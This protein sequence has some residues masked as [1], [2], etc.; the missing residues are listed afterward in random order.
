[1]IQ[2]IMTASAAVISGAGGG[3]EP[4]AGHRR[5]TFRGVAGN[6]GGTAQYL[7]VLLREAVTSGPGEQ[8]EAGV[9]QAQGREHRADQHHPAD[10][11]DERC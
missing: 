7:R 9:E 4:P 11:G 6:M 5:E 1:M 2:C 3:T 8:G 10:P